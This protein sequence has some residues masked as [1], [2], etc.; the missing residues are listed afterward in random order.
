M[1]DILISEVDAKYLQRMD[2]FVKN[3][4]YEPGGWLKVKI[5]IL[6]YG[7]NS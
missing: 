2:T 1:V 5:H 4:K 6:F 3:Q 7:D